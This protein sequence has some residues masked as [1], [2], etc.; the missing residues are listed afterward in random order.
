MTEMIDADRSEPQ[1]K[2]TRGQRIRRLIIGILVAILL[3][4]V[5]LEGL[6]SLD[7]LHFQH[8]RDQI[9]LSNNTIP[10]PAGWTFAPGTYRLVLNTV[11]MLDDGTRRVPDTNVD[12]SKMLVFV[13]DSVTFGYGVDD[14]ETF[15]NL[16]A[17]QLPDVH[18]YN[19]G[20]TAFNSTNILRQVQNYADADAIVYL[21]TSND[22]DGE[23]IIDFSAKRPDFSWIVLYAVY[24]PPL[25]F[26][27]QLRPPHDT[28]RYL[29]DV[30][31]IS[32][33]PN[34]LVVGYDD[35]LT[36][37]TPGAV[38][39]APYTTRNSISDPHPDAEGHRFIAEQLLPL[40]RERF[41]L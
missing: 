7:P 10:A 40:I 38:R 12:A 15:A 34:T 17:R 31:Q 19:T 28:D 14:D 20:I 16:I 18:V 8:F 24:L 11:T 2:S 23:Y 25:L 5:L 32:A 22:D 39:I 21:I 36:P 26:P 33:Y 6:L 37:I 9:V 41:D 3:F 1:A 27:Q 4:F 29:R 13:G 30:A 35:T